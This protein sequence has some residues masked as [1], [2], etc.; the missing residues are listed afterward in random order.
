M[1]KGGTLGH[2]DEKFSYVV[3]SREKL[4]TA[5]ARIVRHP[6]K[7][8]RHV[9]LTLCTT[10]G[11]KTLPVTKKQREDYRQARHAHWGDPWID[12]DSS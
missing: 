3:A 7:L 4:P 11:I 9:L 10:G 5:P 8:S 1:L 12:I 2:E 6:K